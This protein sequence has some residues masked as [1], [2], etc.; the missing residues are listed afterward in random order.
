MFACAPLELWRWKRRLV[1]A[2]AVW[3]TQAAAVVH[4]EPHPVAMRLVPVPNN[5]GTNGDAHV[6]ESTILLHKSGCKTQS[7]GLWLQVAF[8][9]TCVSTTVHRLLLAKFSDLPKPEFF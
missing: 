7:C 4:L 8:F 2:A 1:A 3:T 5:G 9:Q 6:V